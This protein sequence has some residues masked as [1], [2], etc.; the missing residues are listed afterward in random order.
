MAENSEKCI[1]ITDKNGN[2]NYAGIGLK[3][4]YNRINA[5]REQAEKINFEVVDVPEDKQSASKKK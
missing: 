3:S 5:R 1:A 4:I 2:V